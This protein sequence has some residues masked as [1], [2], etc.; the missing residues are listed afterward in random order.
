MLAPMSLMFSL[1]VLMKPWKVLASKYRIVVAAIAILILCIMSACAS[2]QAPGGTKENAVTTTGRATDQLPDK[3]QNGAIP[4]GEEQA[5]DTLPQS[6]ITSKQA[7]SSA[8]PSATTSAKSTTGQTNSQGTPST[9][10]S[11]TASNT[12]KKNATGTESTTAVVTTSRQT[13]T[14]ISPGSY[15]DNSRWSPWS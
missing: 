8:A 1:G 12:T 2:H 14:T 6:E 9:I 4:D 3:T 10:V 11:T 7:S 13:T 15:E 5:K